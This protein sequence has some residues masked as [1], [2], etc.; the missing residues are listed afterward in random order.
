MQV[1]YPELFSRVTMIVHEDADTGAESIGAGGLVNMSG[2][3]FV[4]TAAHCIRWNPRV[5]LEEHWNANGSSREP[6]R[7][8]TIV[9]IGAPSSAAM[10]ML[11]SDR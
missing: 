5:I 4:A 10:S 1:H 3:H 7:F 9:R 6:T 11:T 2:R 8:A